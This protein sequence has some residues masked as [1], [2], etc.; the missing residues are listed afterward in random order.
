MLNKKETKEK[1]GY[2]VSVPNSLLEDASLKITDIGAYVAMRSFA[3]NGKGECWA[4]LIEIS[5]RVQF[6]NNTIN[7]SISILEENGHIEISGLKK[8]LRGGKESLVI[9]FPYNELVLKTPTKTELVQK[10]HELVRIPYKGVK[11]IAK[12]EEINSLHEVPAELVSTTPDNISSNGEGQDPAVIEKNK[13]MLPPVD[14]VM[15]DKEF[16]N[17]IESKDWSA[18]TDDIPF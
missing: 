17:F 1:A 13:I 15:S 7:I 2:V 10:T 6:D 9:R 3:Q 11:V 4:S 14:K 18:P 16:A 12:Q 8:N 5:K